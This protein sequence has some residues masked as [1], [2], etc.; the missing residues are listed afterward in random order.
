M[1]EYFE[2]WFLSLQNVNFVFSFK[3]FTDSPKPGFYIDIDGKNTIARITLWHTGECELE[4]LDVETEKTIM[5]D[6]KDL[7]ESS[8][9]DLELK[10]FFE[11]IV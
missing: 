6:H 9:L 2:K 10:K 11:K 7:D 8:D 3:K 5:C 1:L 4:I